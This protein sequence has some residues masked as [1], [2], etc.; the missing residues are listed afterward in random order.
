M[1]PKSVCILLEVDASASYSLGGNLIFLLLVFDN[2]L[3]GNTRFILRMYSEVRDGF[4][5]HYHEDRDCL[6]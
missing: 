6:T 2:V 1:L 4:I 3:I 5:D